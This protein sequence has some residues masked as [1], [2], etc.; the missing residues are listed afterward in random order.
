MEKISK[1][2]ID[3]NNSLLP[4]MITYKYKFISEN[5]YRFFRGTNHVFYQDLKLTKTLFE[6][7][8][9]WICGDLHLENFGSFKSDNRLVYFDLNDFDE[10][11]LAPCCFEV[12]RTVTS[13][14]VAF[15]ALNIE[16][17]KALNMAQL[18]LKSYSSL[19]ATGKP[20]YIEANTAKG[21]VCDFLIAVAKRKSKLLLRNRT[22]IKNK[23]LRLLPDHPKHFGLHKD[24]KQELTDHIELWLKNDGNSPYNYKILDIV[25]R[26]AGTG[27][28]GQ[29]RY[30]ILLKSLNK[31]GEKYLLLDM[32]Q[33]T[34]SSLAPF[35]N[36]N[37]PVWKNEAERIISI[38]RMMQN[39]SPALLSTT[40]FKDEHYVIAEMQPTEDSLNFKLL[41]KDY[42]NMYQVIDDMGMLTASSQLR[43]SGIRGS[44]I[45]DE[46]I[47]F[48]KNTKWQD[49]VLKYAIQ[50]ALKVKKDYITYLVDYKKGVFKTQ[51]N[52]KPKDGNVFV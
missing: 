14:F 41:N 15:D 18:F 52:S 21:I 35:I 34:K 49:S 8:T 23:K 47:E 36:T 42:R 45:T 30:L 37:Q 3:F 50:Y 24:L 12:L 39:R 32:K 25:F 11:I 29:K 28:V 38:Q 10:A 2:L 33:A 26:L 7:P 9:T 6:S 40:I 31:Y 4:E 5:L 16:Q 20:N 1:Q 13:I 43:S 19:L 22:F 27:S 17:K 46:L 48:G 51:I 44:A